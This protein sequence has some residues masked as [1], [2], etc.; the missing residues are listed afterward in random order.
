MIRSNP[1][2]IQYVI[3]KKKDH[4]ELVFQKMVV[5]VI[6]QFSEDIL[7]ML[8]HFGRD[9]YLFWLELFFTVILKI[10]V[11][12]FTD[13]K[14]TYNILNQIQK[15]KETSPTHSYNGNQWKRFQ[16]RSHPSLSMRLNRS[17]K[18][19]GWDVTCWG[20]LWVKDRSQRW[21][22]DFILSQGKR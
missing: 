21:K 16:E 6:S 19:G 14:W 10:I 7:E 12:N 2:T 22:R 15:E 1:M 8:W 18:G 9:N 4:F 11:L 3:W 13:K 5:L 17:S 20:G